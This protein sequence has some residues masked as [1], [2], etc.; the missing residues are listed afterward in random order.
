MVWASACV[1]GLE[2]GLAAWMAV[3]MLS[4]WRVTVRK[5]RGDARGAKQTGGTKNRIGG[6]LLDLCVSE[7]VGVRA[8]GKSLRAH[9]LK[10]VG[11]RA[12]LPAIAT[13][14]CGPLGLPGPLQ[15]ACGNSRHR[16]LHNINHT[17]KASKQ[18]C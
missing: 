18:A 8:T 17:R 14:R 11:H 10:D 12:A 5:L 15:E 13:N 2:R 4:T 7:S 9:P 3:E 6:Q 16:T 1:G